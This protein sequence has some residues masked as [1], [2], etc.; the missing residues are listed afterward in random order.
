MAIDVRVSIGIPAPREDVASYAMD[1]TNDPDWIGGIRTAR[2]LT[3]PPLRVGSKV[4]RMA[5]FLGR[6]IEYV[7]EITEL[8]PGI[9]IEMTS[10]R[11]PFPMQVGYHF[12]D[13]NGGSRATIRVRGEAAGFYR[14]AAPLLSTIVKARLGWDLGQLRARF[15]G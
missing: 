12:D 1:P 2:E 8:E 9:R 15:E 10:V 3:D 13:E 11:A 5:R 7:L 6:R 4:E 14:V